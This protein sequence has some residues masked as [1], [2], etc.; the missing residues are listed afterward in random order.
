MAT[1]A[2]VGSTRTSSTPATTP[3]ARAS[4]RPA[5]DVELSAVRRAINAAAT[6]AGR[7]IAIATRRSTSPI[8]TSVAIGASSC[9]TGAVHV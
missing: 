8:G 3:N 9:G 5:F 2:A 7:L 1:I 4:V 6:A